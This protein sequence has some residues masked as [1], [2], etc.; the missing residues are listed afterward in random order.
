MLS[1]NM[2]Q[3]FRIAATK[4]QAEFSKVTHGSY[5]RVTKQSVEDE[6]QRLLSEWKAR[7]R[8]PLPSCE[9]SGGYGE[10]VLRYA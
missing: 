4:R 1:E 6:A 5:P 8:R 2:L 3:K 7:Q 10:S 9:C